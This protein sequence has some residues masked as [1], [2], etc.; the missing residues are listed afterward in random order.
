MNMRK[1]S[2][3]VLVGS[4]LMLAGPAWAQDESVAGREFDV[5]G[6]TVTKVSFRGKQRLPGR[7]TL[8]FDE[9]TFEAPAVEGTYEQRGERIR[10]KVSEA[11]LAEWEALWAREFADH[12]ED[13]GYEVDE[14]ACRTTRA[15]LRARL[16]EG[17]L[18]F[19][20][21]YKFRC[22][23][24]GDFGTE[25]ARI[26][27]RFKGRG[28]EAESEGLPEFADVSWN[29]QVIDLDPRYAGLPEAGVTLIAAP[30]PGGF[31]L[32]LR[33]ERLLVPREEPP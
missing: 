26:L 10:M 9:D 18:R 17:I 21:K 16:E 14:V 4:S 31:E 6:T 3:V 22:E 25:R 23:A 32:E 12:L 8:E 28:G 20:T 7:V 27:V 24:S 30:A 5:V 1:S 29:F 15:R 11:L 19:M 33:R 13:Q 2:V